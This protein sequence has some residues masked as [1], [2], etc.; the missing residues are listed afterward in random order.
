MVID[1][2]NLKLPLE[3]FGSFNAT[4]GV[5]PAYHMNTYHWISVR[6]PDAA[7]D[8]LERLVYA[9]YEAIKSRKKKVK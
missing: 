5:Y 8:Q 3:M 7:D 4:Y 2:V 1:R 6:L 9:S